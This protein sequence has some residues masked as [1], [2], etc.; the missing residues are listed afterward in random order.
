MYILVLVGAICGMLTTWNGFIVAT[1]RIMMS[2]SRAKLLPSCFEKTNA[3]TGA[4]TAG[5]VV[6][7]LVSCI[8]VCLGMGIIDPIT[9][10]SSTALVA[11][12]MVTS[13]TFLKLRR[14]EPELHRPYRV[15]C[16]ILVGGFALVVTAISFIGFF[17]PSMPMFTGTTSVFIFL[18]WMT[19]GL[20]MWLCMTNARTSTSHEERTALLFARRGSED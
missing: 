18:G 14:R 16:G 8:G 19:I 1:S 10:M 15:P 6:C 3:K 4:P 2:M 17:I 11:T 12:W 5:L 7:L 9:N 20:V 13:L